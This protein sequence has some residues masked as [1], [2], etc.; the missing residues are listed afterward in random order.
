MK[1][2][3]IL[4][5]FLMAAFFIGNTA[6]AQNAEGESPAQTTSVTAKKKSCA[7]GANK[8]ACTKTKASCAGKTGMV[9]SGSGSDVNASAG[10]M[11]STSVSSKAVAPKGCA[12]MK[13]KKGKGCCASK[14]AGKKKSKSKAD[15]TL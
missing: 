4:A 12:G 6:H 11:K 9:S 10:T 8:K 5:T 7:Y 13:G 15:P 14:M 1:K 2:T 3:I